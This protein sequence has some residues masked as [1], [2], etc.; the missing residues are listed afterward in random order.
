MIM[1]LVFWVR[2]VCKSPWF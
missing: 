1:K 2:A